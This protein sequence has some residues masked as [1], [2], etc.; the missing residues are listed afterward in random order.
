MSMSSK[1]IFWSEDVKRLE[2]IQSQVE[3]LYNTDGTNSSWIELPYTTLPGDTI[4]VKWEFVSLPPN[5]NTFGIIW[6]GGDRTGGNWRTLAC[7]VS[8]R[9]ASIYNGTIGMGTVSSIGSLP[10]PITTTLNATQKQDPEFPMTMFIQNENSLNYVHDGTF[11][12]YT[13]QFT[14]KCWYCKIWRSNE[15]I[16]D[17][18]PASSNSKVGMVNTIDNT[19]YTSKSDVKFIGGPAI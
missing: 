10:G 15:L 6:G 7:G 5:N 1:Q 19:F 11:H 14:A 2:W 18:V 13:H 9:G 17:L 4:E 16:F 3:G 8:E 12:G